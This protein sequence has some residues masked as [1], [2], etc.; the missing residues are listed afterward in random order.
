M[1]NQI[2]TSID[3]AWKQTAVQW[4][5]NASEAIHWVGNGSERL[6]I[7]IVSLI[8]TYDSIM[9]FGA[10]ILNQGLSRRGMHF[11]SIW[12]KSYE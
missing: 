11:V 5:C 9:K 4:M 8:V 7:K 2:K 1:R 10:L 3:F 12:H 6:I